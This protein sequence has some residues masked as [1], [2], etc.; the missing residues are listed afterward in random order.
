MKIKYFEDTDTL[1]IKLNDKTPTETKE[2][3]ENIT[4]EIDEHGK[5]IGLTFEHAR[6]HSGKID[7]SYETIAA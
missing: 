6:E 2:L 3:N 5:I 7:F 1:F 4:L